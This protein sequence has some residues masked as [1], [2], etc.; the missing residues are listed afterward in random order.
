MTVA[1][2]HSRTELEARPCRWQAPVGADGALSALLTAGHGGL[3]KECSPVSLV[4]ASRPGEWA[5]VCKAKE[6]GGI[7]LSQYYFSFPH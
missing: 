6:E 5:S 1:L 3:G 7:L 2:L 4:L